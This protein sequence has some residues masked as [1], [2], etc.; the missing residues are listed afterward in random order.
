M[1][2]SAQAM[3]AAVGPELG[4]H[5]WQSTLFACAAGLLTLTLRR[6]QARA[7]YWLWLAAS[8]KFLIPFSLLVGLGAHVSL[9]HA[10]ATKTEMYMA[11]EQAGLP[12]AD[13]IPVQ[14]GMISPGPTVVTQAAAP[15]APRQLA[16]FLPGLLL[17]VWLCGFVVVLRRW[18]MRWRGMSAMLREAEPLCLGREVETLRRLQRIEIGGVRRRIEMVAARGQM[19]PGV[20]GIAR[21]VLV[22]PEGISERLD[23]AHLEAVLAHKDIYP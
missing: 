16:Y 11:M 4:N 5:L 13:P 21:P 3:W 20:F 9:P 1:M 22:W 7:R 2:S 6:N 10:A 15:L 19:E 18:W 23:D 8:V 17:A 12:F 14:T